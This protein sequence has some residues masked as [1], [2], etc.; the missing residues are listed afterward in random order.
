MIRILCNVGVL[1][2][3]YCGGSSVYRYSSSGSTEVVVV[4]V[5]EALQKQ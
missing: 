4:V 1:T 3:W 5:V 2:G